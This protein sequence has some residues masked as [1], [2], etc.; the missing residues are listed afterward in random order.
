MKWKR[1]CK[2]Q[3]PIVCELRQIRE[4]RQIPR[5]VL[6][7]AMG[8]HRLTLGR[9]ERGE[10]LPSLQALH[11]WAAYLGVDIRTGERP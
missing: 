4:R 10:T 11:D 9:W 6:E 1:Y 7:H 2:R 8:Y 5:K 3:Y